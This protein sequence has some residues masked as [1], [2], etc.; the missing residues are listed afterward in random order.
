SEP[1]A[2]QYLCHPNPRQTAIQEG[3]HVLEKFNCGG[4]HTLEMPRWQFE[5]SPADLMAA[6]E[7]HDFEFLRPHFSPPA[8]IDSEKTD[9]RGMG[10]ADVAGMPLVDAEGN[11][12]QD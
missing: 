12:L 5:Y 11:L 6:P 7:F 8:L 1:P 9:R 10:I 4:C 3:K 2:Q